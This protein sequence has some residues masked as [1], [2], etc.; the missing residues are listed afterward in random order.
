MPKDF[1]ETLTSE[2]IHVL[3]EVVFSQKNPVLLFSGGKDS[4][5][6]LDLLYKAMYPVPIPMPIMHID[7]GHNFPET[8]AFRDVVAERYA[9]K[10]IVRNVQDSID[11][12]LAKESTGTITSR[13]QAQA[14]TLKDAIQEFGFDTAVGG[15]R[16]DEE[17]AR[18]KERFFS[19]RSEKGGWQPTK[20]RPELWN[21][22]NTTKN[23]GEHFRVFP[24]SNWTEEDVW[25]YILREKLEIPSL[26]LS[27]KRKMIQKNGV[28]LATC[29]YIQKED[30]DIVE[31]VDV[32]FRTIGDMT[33]TGGVLSTVRSIKELLEENKQSNMNERGVRVDDQFSKSAMEDRKKMGYF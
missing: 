5:V 11:Q 12:G 32:R 20:Q 30:G 23:T 24:I 22:Y 21:I 29:P 27:H 18:A 28:W 15:A 3:R 33:C 17:K 31:T 13:N 6:V 14:V 26:Y 8:I 16:R 1:L 10:L 7:T 25:N 2:A 4:L 19:I 9:V